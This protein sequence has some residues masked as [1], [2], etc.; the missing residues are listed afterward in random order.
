MAVTLQKR[1]GISLSK[2]FSKLRFTVNWEYKD[3]DVDI[4]AIVV[5]DGIALIDEDLVF[6]GNLRHPSKSVRH[7]GDIRNGGGSDGGTET[8]SIDLT[9]LPNDRNEI[10]LTASIDGAESNGNNFGNI[11]K[12]RCE[13]IDDTN[14]KLLA[15]YDVDVDLDM[16]VAGVLCRI[17]RKE[18][19]QFGYETVGQAYPSLES[20]VTH[21][22]IVVA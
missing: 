14:S 8:I 22:G 16:E 1:Q 20:M 12:V 19:N 18:D 6:Y 21:Y 4:E 9:K 2:G 5:D 15:T 3:A 7:L 11:G 13:L 10:I 17:Y